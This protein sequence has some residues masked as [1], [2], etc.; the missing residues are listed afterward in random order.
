MYYDVIYFGQFELMKEFVMFY[1]I[2][3]IFQNII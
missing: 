1:K 2:Q 3:Y